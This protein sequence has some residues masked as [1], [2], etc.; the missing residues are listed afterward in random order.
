MPEIKPYNKMR[1]TIIQSTQQP[2]HITAMAAAITMRQN[3][4]TSIKPITPE[5]CKYLLDA[6]HTSVF[7][8]VNYTFLIDGV[9]R[10][11]LAQ[12]TR[13]R[14]G[15][16][17]SASQHYQDY[18]DYPCVVHEDLC[19]DALTEAACASAFDCY[20][21]LI[22][23][24]VPIEEARQVLPNAAAVNILWTVNARSLINFLR[25]RLC[26]R[27]VAE[28]RIFAKKVLSRVRGSFPELFDYVG[29]QCF[30]GECKQGRMRCKEGIWTL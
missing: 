25:Q 6:E 5:L 3:I 23:L 19:K 2:K 13:H 15:S 29:P 21:R 1:A 7:E 22:A 26:N 16:F 17:T 12:I 11:F 18:R 9:S 20:Q 14:M 24:G 4:D 8:H 10:S 27:N 28:M 30:M